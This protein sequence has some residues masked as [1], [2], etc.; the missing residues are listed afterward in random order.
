MVN[1]NPL[2]KAMDS[3]NW[4]EELERLVKSGIDI[5]SIDGD[6]QTALWWAVEQGYAEQVEYLLKLQANPNLS[7][8]FEKTPLM[9]AVFQGGEHVE[10]LVSDLIDAGANVNARDKSGTTALMIC[11]NLKAQ[12]NLLNAGADVNAQRRGGMTVLH[13]VIEAV[14]DSTRCYFIEGDYVPKKLVSN[15]IDA[16]RKDTFNGCRGV[17]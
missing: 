16:G 11:H 10:K 1:E 12:E 6:K 15:L 13:A 8:Y 17:G 2:I 5:N 3:V 4:K 7:D 9:E 14:S